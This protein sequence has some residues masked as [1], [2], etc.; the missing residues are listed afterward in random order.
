[1]RSRKSQ[2]FPGGTVGNR[3][4]FDPWVRKI[5]YRRKWQPT[6]VFLPVTSHGQRDLVGCSPWSRK[7]LDMTEQTHTHTPGRRQ[8]STHQ[9]T[10]VTQEV[11]RESPGRRQEVTHGRQK[12]HRK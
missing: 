11:D 3:P 1:M 6:P 12:P 8:E 4:G 5:P 9:E 7:E 10:E 2:G